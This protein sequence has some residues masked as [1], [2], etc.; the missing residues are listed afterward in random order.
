MEEVLEKAQNGDKKA[1]EEIIKLIEKDLYNI[2]DVKLGNSEDAK[3]AVQEALIKFYKNIDKIQ[4]PQYVK[5][6]A[7]RILINECNNIYKARKRKSNL[8]EKLQTN[9]EV[10]ENELDI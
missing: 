1:Y 6:W 4:N 2:A 7:V 5:T 10:K 3:D 9:V 8:I